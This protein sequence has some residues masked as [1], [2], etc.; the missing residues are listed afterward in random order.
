[1]EELTDP[2]PEGL[3][4]VPLRELTAKERA[5]LEFMLQP[6]F[7]GRDELRQQLDV[8]RVCGESGRGDPTIDLYVDRTS[9]PPAPVKRRIPIEARGRDPDG[10]GLEVLL[11]VLDGYMSE[12]EVYREDSGSTT[13]PNP[14]GLALFSLDERVD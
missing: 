12:L 4:G 11:H 8:T 10:I 3:G 13:M 2:K 1:M 14:D 7:P 5:V 6:D 9:A